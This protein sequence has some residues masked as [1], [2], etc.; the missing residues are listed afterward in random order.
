[1]ATFNNLP[2]E[3]VHHIWSFLAFDQAGKRHLCQA[4]VPV[5]RR[6]KFTRTRIETMKRLQQFSALVERR[7]PFLLWPA[8]MP[9][10][11]T[12]VRWLTLP[13]VEIYDGCD[14]DA[15]RKALV[16][17]RRILRYCSEV[18][19]LVCGN[20]GPMR[21]LLS[22][23]AAPFLHLAKLQ[24]LSLSSVEAESGTP[25]SQGHFVRLRRFPALRVLSLSLEWDGDES[26]AFGTVRTSRPSATGLSPVTDLSL[27]GGESLGTP[28]AALF[29][30]DFAQ[31]TRLELAVRD[32]VDLGAF[33]QA[34]PVTITDLTIHLADEL[35]GDEIEPLHVE[36]DLARFVHLTDLTLGA[37]MYSPACELF[38]TL[39][40]YLPCLRTLSLET[41]T[42]LVADKLLNFV[43]A[44]GGPC[45]RLE[46]VILDSIDAHWFPLPSEHPEYPGVENGIFDFRREWLRPKWTRRF[47]LADARELIAAAKRVGVELAGETVR[48][49][50]YDEVRA[51]EEAYLQT[52]RDDIL[53]SLRDL[54][55]E[56]EV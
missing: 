24:E 21:V 25:L 29:I 46:T 8:C 7:D 4:L 27:Q 26:E 6:H 14:Q 49:V 18:E 45:R 23:Q 37:H 13:R 39:S 15:S 55:E 17:V 16:S 20:V 31:L 33:L 44:R 56:L 51:R 1:M 42:Q 38:P 48:A 30:A 2:I 41:G 10:V 54:F 47:G 40:S 53:Y 19:R 52:R 12:C 36:A 3:L 22:L 11:G 43:L 5:V 28:G 32:H 9:S 34:C 50:E 35:E